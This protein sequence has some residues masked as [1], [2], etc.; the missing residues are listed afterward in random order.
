MRDST[1][2][3]LSW[4][5]WVQRRSLDVP[6]ERLDGMVVILAGL[7]AAAQSRDTSLRDLTAQL[8]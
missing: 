7:G 6:H 4:Q 5:G 1:A 2:W 8:L 3:S